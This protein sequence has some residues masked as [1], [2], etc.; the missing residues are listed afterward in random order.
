MSETNAGLISG[1]IEADESEIYDSINTR[2]TVTEAPEMTPE[3]L[4]GLRLIKEIKITEKAFKDAY[5]LL[6]TLDQD[7]KEGKDV[8]NSIEAE[9]W[10]IY[11]Y[12]L[13]PDIMGGAELVKHKEA[14]LREEYGA[15]FF[16]L[17]ISIPTEKWSDCYI[18]TPQGNK[19]NAYMRMREKGMI[20]PDDNPKN[21]LEEGDT[22]FYNGLRLAGRL[23]SV[24]ASG[25]YL[26]KDALRDYPWNHTGIAF[27]THD[28]L[29][30]YGAKHHEE[31]HRMYS[32]HN[33][34]QSETPERKLLDEIN[35]YRENVNYGGSSWYM[36]G[37]VN[38]SSIFGK[39]TSEGY[40]SINTEVERPR[41]LAA[42]KTAEYL[43]KHLPQSAITHILLNCENLDQFLSWGD[44]SESDLKEL[45]QKVI[46][47][48]EPTNIEEQDG[49]RPE[50]N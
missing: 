38:S 33:P 5:K 21:A 7:S 1:N 17:T 49:L 25:I 23:G 35:A 9:I 37:E 28:A 3:Q 24:R 27:Y 44:V 18:V 32:V 2:S 40:A 50:V 46:D 16:P 22:L 41:I 39:L 26:P 15:T 10:H 42:C 12:P 48:P 11:H 34:F 20:D 31:L 6:G 29:E 4:E 36:D 43:S 13:P 19:V 8:R 45:G 14:E 30:K 47:A